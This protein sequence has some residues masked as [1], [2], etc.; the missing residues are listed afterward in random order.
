VRTLSRPVPMHRT[1]RRERRDERR[2]LKRLDTLSTR[3]GELHAIDALL[4]ESTDLVKNG[5][6][7]NAWFSVADGQGARAVAGPDLRLAVDRPVTGACLVGS[8]VQAGGGV[9]TVRSQRV[10]RTLDLVWHTLREDADRPVRWCPGPQVRMMHVL[11]LT[12]WN[13][14]PERTRRDVVVLLEAAQQTAERERARCDDERTTLASAHFP[15]PS[16]GVEATW[17]QP[18]PRLS[19]CGPGSSSLC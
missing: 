11:E 13:D 3:L 18:D 9:A 17:S 5:W 12:Y 2:R 1:G 15:P 16:S 10:Q 4:T 14:A 6:V 8:I 19:S 7:Q